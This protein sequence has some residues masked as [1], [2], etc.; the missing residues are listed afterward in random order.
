MGF[1]GDLF[2][3]A[4]PVTVTV[5]GTGETFIC[6]P[7][8]LLMK[9]ALEA[10]VK[11][12]LSCKVGSCGSCRATIVEGEGVYPSSPCDPTALLHKEEMA[13]GMVIACQWVPKTD[14]TVDVAIGTEG[15]KRGMI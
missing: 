1:F 3:K 10:N 8:Q 2:K 15:D 7:G 9:A 13:N 11:W 14:I 12:P 6:K 5:K 4:E